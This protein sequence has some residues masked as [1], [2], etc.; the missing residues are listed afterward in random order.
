MNRLKEKYVKEL[1]PQL[2]KQLGLDN[3]NAVPQIKKVVVNVGVGKTLKDPKLL[4]AIINDLKTIT[5]QMP[6]KTLARKSIAGFKIRENQVVGLIVTLRG[7]RMYDF[8]DKLVN[9]AMP[10]IRDFRGIPAESFDGRGNYHVGIREQLVFPEI[11][12]ESIDHVFSMEISIVTNARQDDRA[13]ELLKSMG[14]PFSS[15]QTK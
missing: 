13:R 4:E 10:R 12:E 9:A 14:F 3:V 2:Q 1:K 8:L 7:R 5:G 15:E 11:S 6:V